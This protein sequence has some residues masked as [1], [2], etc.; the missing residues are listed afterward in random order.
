MADSEAFDPDAYL[1]QKVGQQPAAGV[2]GFD[3]DTYLSQKLAAPPRIQ[4]APTMNAPGA[5]ASVG[6]GFVQG[7]TL[8]FGDEIGGA[9]QALLQAMTNRVAAA[10]QKGDAG[11][12][13]GVKLLDALGIEGRYPQEVGGVYRAGRDEMREQD[14]AAVKTHPG[15]YLLGALGGGIATGKALPFPGKNASLLAKIGTGALYGG[16]NSA[17]VST[18]DS[19]GGVLKDASGI[20]GAE[21][22]AQDVGGGHLGKA[23]LDALG[24][25]A[26]G[27]GVLAGL[28]PTLAR[29]VGSRMRE[30]G[31]D[32]AR[33]ALYNVS[34]RISS[35]KEIPK[36]A[37]ETVLQSGAM[38]WGSNAKTLAHNLVDHA[39]R[40]GAA[41]GDIIE[42]AGQHGVEVPANPLMEA[43]MQDASSA[44]ANSINKKVP[45]IFK[46]AANKVEQVASADKP[47]GLYA[48]EMGRSPEATIPIAQMENLKRSAQE[49]ANSAYKQLEP[50]AIGEANM[51]VAS[52]MRQA[53]EDALGRA[54]SAAEPS[55]DLAQLADE[56]TAAKQY[57][58]RLAEARDLA[59]VGKARGA[60]RTAGGLVGEELASEALRQVI[61]GNPAEGL[62]DLA[63]KQ[64]FQLYRSRGP[65]A[66][67][68][69]LYFG[70]KAL[71]SPAGNRT[72]QQILLGAQRGLEAANPPPVRVRVIDPKTGETLGGDY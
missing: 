53:S 14:A 1:A 49:I 54:S 6:R 72:A 41:V 64:A 35:R 18:A 16:I 51:K 20:S 21:E 66:M 59:L 58:G 63:T 67:A 55:S 2:S 42:R 43:L 3:P 13:L 4:P 22:A 70:G 5:L 45:P 44:N 52:R 37:V 36:E 33:R 10:H 9:G 46:S 23:F 38:P 28:G 39:E 47:Y 31:I 32:S 68:N 60:S 34:Q 27:G 26:L 71:A 24:A 17:G 12:S 30:E 69:T 50:T 62:K 57:F 7:G 19:A 8:G 56:F 40:A 11:S 29:G 61:N 48:S 15:A 65:S 25:G